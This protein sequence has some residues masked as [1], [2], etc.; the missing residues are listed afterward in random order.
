M[1]NVA[2][3]LRT[4]PIARFASVRMPCLCNAMNTERTNILVFDI[5]HEETKD[6]I[7]L[8]KLYALLWIFECFLESERVSKHVSLKTLE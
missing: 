8:I 1:K 3:G 5:V 6:A 7:I 4:V 2:D